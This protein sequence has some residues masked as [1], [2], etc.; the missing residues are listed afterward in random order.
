M[1]AIIPA[2]VI[3]GNSA[4]S[5]V[6]M[7]LLKFDI[8]TRTLSKVA[9]YTAGTNGNGQIYNITGNVQWN[10]MYSD[11]VGNLFASEGASGQIWSFTITA[12]F[13]AQFVT[14]GPVSTLADGARCLAAN[15]TI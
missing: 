11:S 6:S 15:G 9:D 5:Q 3:N 14:A 7:Q 12:P 13:T 10:A 1:Y 2:N 4:T 8:N